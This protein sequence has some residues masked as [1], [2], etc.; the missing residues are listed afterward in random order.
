MRRN[1]NFSCLRKHHLRDHHYSVRTRS[2][3]AAVWNAP[4]GQ[5]TT[6][7]PPQKCKWGR[8]NI[9]GRAYLLPLKTTAHSVTIGPFSSSVE[10]SNTFCLF[11]YCVAICHCAYLHIPSWNN[12]KHLNLLRGRM[13]C[14]IVRLYRNFVGS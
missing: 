1:I 8:A 7:V 10:A 2:L 5:T 11:P 14:S 3:R 13:T 4:R 9:L 6:L 12:N